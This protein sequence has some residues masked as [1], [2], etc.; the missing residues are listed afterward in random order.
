MEG[1]LHL[2]I[3]RASLILGRKFTIFLCFT[4]YLRAIFKYKPLGGGGG[5]R[6]AFIWRGY[7]RGGIFNLI[8]S[9]GGV[10]F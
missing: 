3:F 8:G 9:F 4:L 2:K 7:F 5:G 6:G 10:K 1:N